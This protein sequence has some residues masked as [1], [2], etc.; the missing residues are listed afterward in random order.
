MVVVG[1]ESEW[2][3]K[4]WEFRGIR[5]EL[6]DPLFPCPCL[7]S[8]YFHPFHSSVLRSNR[9]SFGFVGDRVEGKMISGTKE[10][11]ARR[12][13]SAEERTSQEAVGSNTDRGR[14]EEKR[15]K[16]K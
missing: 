16:Q 3:L 1:V 11:Q 15:T 13:A 9:C 10:R 5:S 7:R 4:G 12:P 2:T 8:C 6:V 14:K